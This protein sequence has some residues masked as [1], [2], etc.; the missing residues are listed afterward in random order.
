MKDK[1]IENMIESVYANIQALKDENEVLKMK[2]KAYINA[3]HVIKT[4]N[5]NITWTDSR[6]IANIIDK[7]PLNK[8]IYEIVV[9]KDSKQCYNNSKKRLNV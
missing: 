2:L 3:I 5:V 6:G 9:I 4:D 7:T 8:D 1:T